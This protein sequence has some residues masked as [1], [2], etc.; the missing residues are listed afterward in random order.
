MTQSF[1]KLSAGHLG[2]D[3]LAAVALATMTAN[4]TVWKK[5]NPCAP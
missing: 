1:L 3:E 5:I 2:K 4:L